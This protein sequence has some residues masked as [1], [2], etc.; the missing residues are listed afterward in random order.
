ME[1]FVS[2]KLRSAWL[3]LPLRRMLNASRQTIRV[4]PKAIC[5]IGAF[6]SME[7]CAQ[8]LTYIDG[9]IIPENRDDGIY[10]NENVPFEDK[11]PVSGYLF[12][13]Y[14]AYVPRPSTAY[15]C[16]HD[17]IKTDGHGEVSITHQTKISSVK[18]S[19][20]L[21]E[22]VDEYK[23]IG[24]GNI[25]CNE[26]KNAGYIEVD[27]F[28]MD[29]NRYHLYQKIWKDEDG[30]VIVTARCLAR[31]WSVD[32]DSLRSCINK[33]RTLGP[34][35][36][37]LVAN[38][39]LVRIDCNG[40]AFVT[41]GRTKT[42]TSEWTSC[43]KYLNKVL[44]SDIAEPTREK[45]ETRI[46]K[47]FGYEIG[48]VLADRR[49]LKNLRSGVHVKTATMKL[50]SPFSVFKTVKS[51][52]SPNDYILHKLE[53]FSGEIQNPDMKKIE[54]RLGEIADAV[55][56]K[57]AD[58]M[59]MTKSEQLHTAKFKFPVR[60]SLKV[61]IEQISERKIKTV[62]FVMTFED[63]HVAKHEME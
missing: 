21:A 54:T 62:R 4:T 37:T 49:G 61:E 60:Q 40:D 58:R 17:V 5:L 36:K 23:K 7:I 59:S 2:K 9:T 19:E 31:N 34:T 57:F 8:E 55:E 45:H 29:N 30:F 16:E 15:K 33:A 24:V 42:S 32:G 28:I 3:S 11:L 27:E 18:L 44:K 51:Y 56:K 50:A 47:L 39:S 35:E 46:E 41:C 53:F 26:I 20:Y 14:G 6:M 12:G 1:V 22:S 10:G 48:D 13:Q 63:H 38:H 25:K 43:R 52:Y